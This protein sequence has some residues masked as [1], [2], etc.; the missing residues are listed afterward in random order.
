MARAN[1]PGVAGAD[2]PVETHHAAIRLGHPACVQKRVRIDDGFEGRTGGSQAGQFVVAVVGAFEGPGAPA[3]L[4]EP[5]AGDVSQEPD[6]AADA[7]FVGEVQGQRTLVDDRFG[8]LDAHQGPGAGADVAPTIAFG[9]NR[10]DGGGGVVAGGGI[11]GRSIEAR[12]VRDVGEQRAQERAGRDDLP[13]DGD[14]QLQPL[15]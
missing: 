4:E 8:K 2:C 12:G 10:G 3:L 14:G 9:G 6:P 13:E 11:D 15:E 5:E 7:D 1:S